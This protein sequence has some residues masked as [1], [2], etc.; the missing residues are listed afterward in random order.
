[1]NKK[2]LTSRTR[3]NSSFLINNGS[4]LFNNGINALKKLR[5]SK[6][7]VVVETTFM[8]KLNQK[9]F[10]WVILGMHPFPDQNLKTLHR[11]WH[12]FPLSKNVDRP[13]WKLNLNCK[14]SLWVCLPIFITKSAPHIGEK[15][16]KLN[17]SSCINGE[18][19]CKV[20]LNSIILV[21]HCRSN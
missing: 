12:P 18:C 5:I 2:K 13:V 1:M 16:R 20:V 6:G 10:I 19:T 7:V 15:Y 17:E 3:N 14:L 4:F 21:I 11:R 9:K 8:A